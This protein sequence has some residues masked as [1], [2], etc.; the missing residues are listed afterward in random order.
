MVDVIALTEQELDELQGRYTWQDPPSCR[1][2]RQPLDM[3][4]SG[5]DGPA[6]FACTSDEARVAGKDGE[7]LTRATV[8]FSRSQW[9]QPHKSDNRVI[10]L[11]AEVRQLRGVVAE[12]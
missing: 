7:R 8:H 4:D 6:T 12:L 5:G 2:C 9:R 10:A 3:T 11:I 1:V